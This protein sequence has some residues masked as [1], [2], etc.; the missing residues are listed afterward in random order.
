MELIELRDI[1]KV[2]SLGEVQVE[3]LRGVTLNIAQGEFVALVG[4]FPRLR[5][6]D[7]ERAGS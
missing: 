5:P 7:F 1:R 4:A 6:L 3:A 2:Y